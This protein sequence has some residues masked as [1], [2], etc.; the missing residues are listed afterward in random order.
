[1]EIYLPTRYPTEPPYMR[2]MTPMFHPNIS[3][4]GSVCIGVADQ[5]WAP[6]LSLAWLVEQ[7][8]DMITYKS[9]NIDDPWNKEAAE[10]AKENTDRFPADDRTLFKPSEAAAKGTKEKP[11]LNVQVEVKVGQTKQKPAITEKTKGDSVPKTRG[12]TIR[13]ARVRTPKLEEE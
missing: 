9:Y 8:A 3:K 11:E 7:I 4:N 13:V 2:W 1:M 10:W 6:S 5:D 12:T